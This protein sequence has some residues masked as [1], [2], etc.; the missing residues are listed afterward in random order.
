MHHHPVHHRQRPHDPRRGEGEQQ[1]HSR[2]H[3]DL[4]R[5]VQ[6]DPVV[7]VA[8]QLHAGLIAVR[9]QGPEP[10]RIRQQRPAHRPDDRADGEG[11][12]RPRQVQHRVQQGPPGGAALEHGPDPR[13]EPPPLHPQRLRL[14]HLQTQQPPCPGPLHRPEPAAAGERR[15]QHRDAEERHQQA[16]PQRHHRDRVGEQQNADRQAQQHVPQ[17]APGAPLDRRPQRGRQPVPPSPGVS[18]MSGFRGE[19]VTLSVLR[20]HRSRPSPRPAAVLSYLQTPRP[21]AGEPWRAS[22]S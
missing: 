9:R 11:E 5:V 3:R 15:R 14:G 4:E 2:G 22:Q 12:H 21:Q 8:V 10:Q 17:L 16:R 1:T 19:P 6:V 13:R 20:G 7:L 18:G